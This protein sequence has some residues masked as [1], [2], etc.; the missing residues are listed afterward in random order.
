[1]ADLLVRKG[2]NTET[3]ERRHVRMEGEMGVLVLQAKE[4]QDI[5][6]AEATKE[7]FSL[8]PSEGV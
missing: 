3:Q 2:E 1:M 4:C 7:N 8:E 6:E 5:P